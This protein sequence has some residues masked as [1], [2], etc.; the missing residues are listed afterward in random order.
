MEHMYRVPYL[1]PYLVPVRTP[2]QRYVNVYAPLVRPHHPTTGPWPWPWAS[3]EPCEGQGRH[4]NDTSASQRSGEV[5]C[6]FTNALITFDYKTSTATSLAALCVGT[7]TSGGAQGN[8]LT[9]PAEAVF[10]RVMPT[11][12]SHGVYVRFPLE[13]LFL[14]E[15]TARPAHQPRPPAS[16]AH[17]HAKRNLAHDD[18]ITDKQAGTVEY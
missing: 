1:V 4:C 10:L 16:S 7:C 15:R 6:C 13:P 3:A 11:P 17:S 14:S 5:P 2:R 9:W 18:S 12:C 8:P